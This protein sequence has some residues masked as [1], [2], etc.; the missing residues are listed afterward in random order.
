MPVPEWKDI[1]RRAHEIWERQGRPEGRDAEHWRE[2]KKSLEEESKS[3]ATSPLVHNCRPGTKGVNA[4]SDN[5]S[6]STTLLDATGEPIEGS[7]R[8]RSPILDSSGQ[9]MRTS[10]QVSDLAGQLRDTIRHRPLTSALVTFGVGLLL[11]LVA[12]S[13]TR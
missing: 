9:P 10:P 6:Q 8:P 3:P 4:M 13:A 7:V 12:T 5:G 11:G 2:A 1:Q